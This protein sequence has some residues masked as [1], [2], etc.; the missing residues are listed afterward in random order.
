MA[1]VQSKGNC[2][3]CGKQIAKSGA[4][5]HLSTHE[6]DED[7][8]QRCVLIKVEAVYDNN[9]WLFLDMPVTSSLSTLDTFLRKI[10]L[11]CCGHM[12]AFFEDRYEE[13]SM[14]RKLSGFSVGTKLSY[15]YDFGSTTDLKITFVR[16]TFRKKQ[17]DDVRLLVRNEAPKLKC[18]LCD[19]DA[20]WICLECMYEESSMYPF[21]CKECFEKHE[22]EHDGYEPLPV[23]NSPRMGVCGYAGDLDVYEFDPKKITYKK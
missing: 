6:K 8:S 16:E 23:T 20:S 22:E 19:A 3:I 18:S 12:S 1:S 4:A 5:R 2:Y 11:E 17:K 7:N 10:W 13:I 21:F 14:R 15:Q 9:Y